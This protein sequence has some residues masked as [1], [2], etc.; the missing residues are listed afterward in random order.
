MTFFS[1]KDMLDF[2]ETEVQAKS[3]LNFLQHFDDFFL[4]SVFVLEFIKLYC[5]QTNKIK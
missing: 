5:K 2:E 4:I 3:I 1:S